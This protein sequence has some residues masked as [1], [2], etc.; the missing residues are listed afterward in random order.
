MNT[1]EEQIRTA[2][3]DAYPPPAQPADWAGVLRRMP[4]TEKERGRHS[5]IRR[6]SR[7]KRGLA[8]AVALGSAAIGGLII[9]GSWDRSAAFTDRALAALGKGR[10]VEAVFRRQVPMLRVVDL[11]SGTTT[12]VSREIQWSYDTQTRRFRARV[13]EAGVAYPVD[14]APPDPAITGFATSYRSAL[15]SGIA[16]VVGDRVVAGEPVKVIRFPVRNSD[17][18]IAFVEYVSVSARTH[19]PVEVRYASGPASYRRSISYRVRAIASTDQP[20]TWSLPS[21]PRPLGG[22]TR[23][24]QTT[25]REAQAILGGNIAWLGPRFGGLRLSSIDVQQLTARGPSG[26]AGRRA[27]GIRLIYRGPHSMSVTI[28]E[29]TTPQPAYGFFSRQEGQDGVLPGLG[30]ALL[31]CDCGGNTVYPP[32]IPIWR[33]QLRTQG[34]YVTVVSPSRRTLLSAIERL[35]P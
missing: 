24:L 21:G 17:G 20:P 10:F 6:G 35:K 16:T 12:P 22:V 2:L 29:A 28:Q 30:K 32:P 3:Y 9:L 23:S 19:R 5:L 1:V 27:R 14:V 7:F 4:S 26:Q 31:G 13:V 18:S 34:L 15:A 33:A 25:P 11:T 8:A